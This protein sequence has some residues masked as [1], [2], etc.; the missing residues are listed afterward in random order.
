MAAKEEE[1]KI[2]IMR[3]LLTQI[4]NTRMDKIKTIETLATISKTCE[5]VK[6]VINSQVGNSKESEEKFLLESQKRELKNISGFI[7]LYQKEKEDKIKNKYL[8]GIIVC[9]ENFKNI[10]NKVIGLKMAEAA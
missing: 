2:I 10:C 8:D 6:A 7:V 3:K 1:K 4:M 5:I 9:I